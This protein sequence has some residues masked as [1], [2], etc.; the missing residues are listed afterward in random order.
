MA[1]LAGHIGAFYMASDSGAA[2]PVGGAVFPVGGFTNWSVDANVN[3]LDTTNF[4]DAG[5]KTHIAG[6][7]DWTGT[8]EQHWQSDLLSEVGDRVVVR[9]Y[10]NYAS[11]QYYY[12]YAHVTGLTE[13]A[14]VDGLVEQGL[15]FTGEGI[16]Y[17]A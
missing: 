5:W 15:T 11:D 17:Q 13:G 16:L 1:A 9:F 6:L 2:T 14:E 3:I 12:G 10:T 7:K 8:A 4:S